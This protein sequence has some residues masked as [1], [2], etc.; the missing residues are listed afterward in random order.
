MALSMMNKK[1]HAVVV[2]DVKSKRLMAILVHDYLKS[3]YS[4]H[5]PCI[6]IVIEQIGFKSVAQ[7]FNTN[8]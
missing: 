5:V 3:K 4:M 8:Y 1:A 2:S 6:A 7:D